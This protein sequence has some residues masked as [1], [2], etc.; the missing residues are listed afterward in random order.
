MIW[1][2]TLAAELDLWQT[3]GQIHIFLRFEG[4]SGR[5]CG[6]VCESS[7]ERVSLDNCEIILQHI[8]L[9]SELWLYVTDFESD[10]DSAQC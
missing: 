8:F 9:E 7:P 4:V 3:L 1:K 6:N 2:W 5:S 10:H